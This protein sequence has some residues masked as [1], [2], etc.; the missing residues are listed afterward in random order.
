VLPAITVSPWSEI[1]LIFTSVA[2]IGVTSVPA[3]S[4]VIVWDVVP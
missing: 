4:H 1:T 3:T 2:L